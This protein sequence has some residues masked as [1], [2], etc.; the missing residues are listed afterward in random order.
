MR[1]SR[2]EAPALARR[3]AGHVIRPILPED[4]FDLGRFFRGASSADR[5]TRFMRAMRAWA[6]KV[7]CEVRIHLEAAFV[8]QISRTTQSPIRET[9]VV[10]YQ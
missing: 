7:G 9:G 4:G 8:V 3:A 2:A 1:L 10:T 6:R 5:Y